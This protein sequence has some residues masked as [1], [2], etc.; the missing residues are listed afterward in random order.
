MFFCLLK[1]FLEE[2]RAFARFV[3]QKYVFY[4][5]YVMIKQKKRKEKMQRL[6]ITPFP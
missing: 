4:I 2:K 1:F 3:L 5:M 6:W